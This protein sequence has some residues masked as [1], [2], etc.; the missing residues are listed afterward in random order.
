MIGII[1]L[2]VIV[3]GVLAYVYSDPSSD[4][5]PSAMP[6]EVP[7]TITPATSVTPVKEFNMAAEKFSFNP[8]SLEVN[9]GDTVIIHLKSLDVEHGIA[10]REFG[11]SQTVPVG[12]EKTVEFTAS[13]KGTFSFFC[14][15]FCGEDHRDMAGTL[16]VE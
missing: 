16:V 11:V 13:K 14:N 3:G 10:I 9:L 12:E 1:V 8:E 7:S 6:S 5:I 4:T 2:V 15:I